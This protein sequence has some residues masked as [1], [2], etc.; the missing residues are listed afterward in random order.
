MTHWQA[1]QLLYSCF[2]NVHSVPGHNVAADLHMKHLNAVCK[3]CIKDLGANKTEAANTQSAKVLGTILPVLEQFDQQNNMPNISGAHKRAS[4]E[5]DQ[6]IIVNELQKRNAFTTIPGR[7][8]KS[9]PKHKDILGG[10]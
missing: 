9:F 1:T 2:V 3:G 5:K 10:Q 8:H 7:K 6:A 4:A